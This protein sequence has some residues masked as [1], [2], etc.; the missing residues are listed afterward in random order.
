MEY[1]SGL[2]KAWIALG[3][4]ALVFLG[5][6]LSLLTMS[7]EERRKDGRIMLWVLVISGAA[8]AFG[9]WSLFF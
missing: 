4:A 9:I 3:I 8:L 1:E 7:R 6:L 5:C 2:G